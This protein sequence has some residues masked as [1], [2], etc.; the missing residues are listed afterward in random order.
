MAQLPDGGLAWIGSMNRMRLSYDG[1]HTWSFE[2]PAFADTGGGSGYP[3]LELIDPDHL[4]VCARWQ[5]RQGCL[6]RREPT[7]T[8]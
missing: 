5:G 6:Y 1:C 8:R 3:G 2:L 4:S 7:G